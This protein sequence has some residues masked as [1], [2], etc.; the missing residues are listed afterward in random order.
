MKKVFVLLLLFVFTIG[1]LCTINY[2]KDFNDLPYS[3]W[4]Y[5]Y[6]SEL[7]EQGVINGYEDGSFKPSNPVTNAEYIKLLVGCVC[8]EYEVDNL[9]SAQSSYKNWFEPYYEY[10]YNRGYLEYP[11]EIEELKGQTTREEMANILASFAF[12]IDLE[13]ALDDEEDDDKLTEDQ[14]VALYGL[15]GQDYTIV[16]KISIG[17]MKYTKVDSFDYDDDE[18]DIDVEDD[19]DDEDIEDE[20][21]DF[22]DYDDDDIEYSLYN[23]IK[24]LDEESI[25][26]I[27]YCSQLGLINGYEDGSFKPNQ[28]MTRA[29]VSTIVYRF[30]QLA[31]KVIVRLTYEPIE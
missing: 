10:A 6:I 21:D 8:R 19:D 24:D 3:H 13:E 23:D 25:D 5:K 17:D 20:D 9:K 2:A 11:Y 14:I 15:E 26:N 31:D 29:E 18:E 16:D 27:F 12:E 28:I 22:I 4:A 7:S 30:K 1:V